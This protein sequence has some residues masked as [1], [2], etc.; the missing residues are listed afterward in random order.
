VRSPAQ[1]LI[2]GGIEPGRIQGMVPGVSL[3]RVVIRVAPAWFRRWW[4]RG[5]S[6]VTLPW[7]VYVAPDV[8][9]WP[10]D[11]RNAIVLHELAHVVQWRRMGVARFLSRYLTEYLVARARGAGHDA[12]Y[13]QIS[14]ERE[15]VSF[16]VRGRS[17]HRR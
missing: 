11:Q 14:L 10:V 6:A 16:S 7:A 9:D 1:L 5:V 3:R 2:A 12:A 17:A 15:A 8:L 13:R 4:G